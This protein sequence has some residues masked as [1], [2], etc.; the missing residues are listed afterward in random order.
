MIRKKQLNPEKVGARIKEI[1]G[2]KTLEEFGRLLGVKNPTVY[3]YET[4]RI[5]DVDMLLKIAALDPLKR[6]IEWLTGG[7]SSLYKERGAPAPAVTE[8]PEDYGDRKRTRLVRVVK[9]L[10]READ[11]DVIDALLKNVEIFSRIPKTQK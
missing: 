8:A 2:Q 9:R 3:R 6:G 4:D 7:A 5:P 11:D 1:R 10:A